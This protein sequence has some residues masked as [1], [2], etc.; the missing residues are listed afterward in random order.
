MHRY[1]H[2]QVIRELITTRLSISMFV[3]DIHQRKNSSLPVT[4]SMNQ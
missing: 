3:Q 1:E 2:H 4:F